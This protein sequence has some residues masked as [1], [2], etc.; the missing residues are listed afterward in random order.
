MRRQA[1]A[2]LPF[3]CLRRRK[4]GAAHLR[5]RFL[6]TLRL[7]ALPGRLPSVSDKIRPASRP[8]VFVL[9]SVQAPLRGYRRASLSRSDWPRCRVAF[10]SS[11]TKSGPLRGPGFLSSLRSRLPCAAIVAL[12]YH[13]PKRSGA[14]SLSLRLG[15]NT[16][17]LCK[18]WFFALA[19]LQASSLTAS[20]RFLV[21][22][23][24]GALFA[25]ASLRLGLVSGPLRGPALVLAP[26]HPGRRTYARASAFSI[27]S[28]I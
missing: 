24:L 5:S 18:S 15:Q 19:P 17:L 11:R 8:W 6:V 4:A 28:K 1:K 2:C 20:P 25:P 22:L 7:A 9:A 23:A 14:Q 13:A 12:P 27:L 16:D 10:P 26:V 3:C 21:T